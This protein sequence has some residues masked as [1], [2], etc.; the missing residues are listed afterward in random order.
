[1]A[2]IIY[3]ESIQNPKKMKT[4]FLFFL[5]IGASCIVCKS[6]NH[7][8]TPTKSLPI[9]A[10]EINY[11]DEII[12]TKN[13]RLDS[14]TENLVDVYNCTVISDVINSYLRMMMP[15]CD[16]EI[17]VKSILSMDCSVIHD[18]TMR[19][20]SDTLKNLAICQLQNGS[21]C[22]GEYL[23]RY[24][25]T[26]YDKYIASHESIIQKYF[27]N[28]M[29]YSHF[30]TEYEDLNEY[31][32][33]SDS[34][35]QRELLT[36]LD[37]EKEINLRCIYALEYAQ[38]SKDDGPFFEEALPYLVAIMSTQE[39]S[40]LLYNVWSTW[41]VMYYHQIGQWDSYE[42]DRI[43]NIYCKRCVEN[44][45]THIS[46]HHNDLLAISQFLLFIFPKMGNYEY[47]GIFDIKEMFAKYYEG[48][49]FH[50]TLG[51]SIVEEN[52]HTKR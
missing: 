7:I 47:L 35:Y 5:I 18:S 8:D 27:S 24:M 11:N 3:H 45:L 50:F 48:K 42:Q 13:I 25:T 41:Y 37:T 31:R 40:P 30:V 34:L 22:A 44:T 10:K 14:L 23:Y 28:N 46:R 1:M 39:Y 20:M 19:A 26:Y 9:Y 4:H 52:E 15:R 33:L 36:L 12:H 51:D 43:K 6:E 2:R 21:R 38:S 17:I 49:I 16:I 29:L 32:I